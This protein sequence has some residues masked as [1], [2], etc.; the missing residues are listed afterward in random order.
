MG[1]QDTDIAAALGRSYLFRDTPEPAL[2]PLLPHATVQHVRRGGSV[3]RS[4]DP[5]THLHVVASGR[6]KLC[7]STADGD[8]VVFETVAAGGTCGE[9]GLF[10]R[11]RDRIADLVALEP[12]VIVNLERAGLIAF[13]LREHVPLLRMLEGL[14]EQVRSAAEDLGALASRDVAGRLALKLL[15]LDAL[16]GTVRDGAP[17][18]AI[19]LTQATLAGMI[20]ATRENVNRALKVLAACGCVVLEGSAVR[21]CDRDALRAR[22]GGGHLAP[23]RRN[24]PR[25]R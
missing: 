21:L 10:A 3:F 22:A 4:G 11:E 20:G 9:P 16:Y 24:A 8:E 14:A 25:V 2:R 12:S 19:P 7:M 6:L 1:V 13:L 5:A 18:T 15:E 23:Y 17:E